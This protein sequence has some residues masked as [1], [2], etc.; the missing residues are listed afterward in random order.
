MQIN[1]EI[2]RLLD[3]R[4]KDRQRNREKQK[5]KQTDDSTDKHKRLVNTLFVFPSK[6]D[7]KLLLNS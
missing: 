3:I 5:N 7:A 2:D 6:T 4:S 1:V